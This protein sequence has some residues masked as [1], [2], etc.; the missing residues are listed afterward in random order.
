ML[1]IE[2]NCFSTCKATRDRQSPLHMRAID[3]FCGTGGFSRGAHAA[4]FDV[5]AAFDIDPVLTSSYATNFPNTK[6]VLQDIGTVTAADAKTAADGEIDLIFGG[7]PCQG[8]SSI[9]RRKKSDP[10]R[11]LLQHFFRLVGELSPAAFVMENVQ[12]LAFKDAKPELESAMALLPETY[13]IIGPIVLDAA[14]FGAPTKRKRIFVIGYD[15]LR[16]EEF[17]LDTINAVKSQPVNVAE[18]LSGLKEVIESKQLSGFDSCRMLR[19]AKLSSYAQKQAAP[20]RTFTGNMKTV[21]TQRVIDRFATVQ[22]GKAD[23][24]GRHPRLSWD[25]QCPTLRAGTG[26]D[27]GSYQSVRPIHPDENRVITVREAAR[28]QGFPDSHRFHPTIWHSFRMIGNSV[29]PIIAEAI[30]KIVAQSI[31]SARLSKKRAA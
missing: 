25:G 20:D 27:M 9:G 4:G 8:F 2:P 26:S 5:S 10:R 28:L 12:G 22:P 15:P 30:L 1:G 31:S 29:S 17:D 14:D 19:N 21:H 3:F 23:L 24:I 11:T 13:T 7:P 6:I 18:A 16:C